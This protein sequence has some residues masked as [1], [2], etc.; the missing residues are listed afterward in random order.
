MCCLRFEGGLV[1]SILYH[2]SFMIPTHPLIFVNILF[3]YFFSY[4][5]I[6]FIYK[7]LDTIY[8]KT[9]IFCFICLSTLTLF[10][11]VVNM[12]AKEYR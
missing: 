3:M 5:F 7:H 4:F 11:A 1:S 10:R 12:E 8:F 2:L 9:S 6:I